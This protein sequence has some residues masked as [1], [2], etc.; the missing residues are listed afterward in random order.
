MPAAAQSASERPGKGTGPTCFGKPA[1]VAASHGQRH[2]FVGSPRADVIVGTRAADE[3]RGRGGNDLVCGGGGN[4]LLAGGAG[5]DRLRGGAGADLVL[6]GAGEDQ[7]E[8]GSGDDRLDGGSGNDRCAGNSGAN[9]YVSCEVEQTSAPGAG[10]P[11]GS[12]DTGKPGAIDHAPSAVN[13]AAVVGEN[14]GATVIDVLSNDTDSDGGPKAVESVTQPQHGKAEVAAGGT[15]LTYEPLAG[16]CNDGEPSDTFTYTLNG[17]SVGTVTVKVTCA[18]TVTAD[19]A[20]TPSFDPDVTDYTTRCNGDPLEVSGRTAE[21]TTVA[22]DGGDPATGKFTASVPLEENQAFSF[23]TTTEAGTD[24]YFVRCLP[25]GFPPWEYEQ[26]RQPSHQLYVVAPNLALS[27]APTQYVV[28]FDSNGVPVWWYHEPGGTMQDAKVLPDG[29][30]AWWNSSTGYVL[31]ETDG[32]FIQGVTAVGGPTDGHELQQLPNGNFLLISSEKVEDLDLTEFGGAEHEDV[33]E[34]LVQ[35]ISPTGELIWNWSTKG[36]IALAETGRWWPTAL[37]RPE[38]RDIIHMNAIEP[39]GENAVMI[40]VRHTDAIYKIDKT[41]GNII[42]KLGG[43]WTPKSL[44][45][46]NDPEGTYPLGGM[47]DIRLLPDGT[48]TIHDNNTG[49]GQPPRAVRY[50]IDEANKTATFVE[51]VSDPLQPSS[52]CCGSSRRSDDG[53]WLMSW[54]GSSYVAE[55]DA[56]H[57]TNFRLKFGGTLFSYRAVPVQDG[58]LSVSSLR[59]GMDAMNP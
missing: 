25:V 31:R 28:I 21:G 6:G 18:T 37:S 5:E 32:T 52:F 12:T 2:I 33:E 42:W 50:A 46:V 48:I 58:L 3:I 51:Q 54:G 20:L 36:H 22:V 11:G 13:D 44:K 29:S 35:E 57:Q 30:L 16:Y 10:R 26:L 23:T 47:H 49:L 53:S 24:T 39:V 27:G 17:G 41:T 59:A 45:V 8:G 14:S 1:T 4:D 7:L 34:M 38:P 9:T 56:A 43:T 55:Y 19:Q 15:G 40:S